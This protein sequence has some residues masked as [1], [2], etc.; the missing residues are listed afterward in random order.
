VT[1]QEWGHCPDPTPLLEFLRGKVSDRK[2][3]LFG[4]ACCRRI[5][6]LIVHPVSRAAVGVAERFAEGLASEADRR[7]VV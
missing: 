7:A 4:C 1:E 6:H 5:W 3:R 2:L